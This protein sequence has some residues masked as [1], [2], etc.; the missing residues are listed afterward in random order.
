MIYGAEDIRVE[1]ADD[2]IRKRPEMYIGDMG[3]LGAA[4]LIGL[5][6]E[7]LAALTVNRGTVPCFTH[8]AFLDVVLDG[9]EA[10]VS[11][12]YHPNESPDLSERCIS[13]IGNRNNMQP[14]EYA[15]E[16]GLNSVAPLPILSALSTGLHILRSG[17]NGV[18][19]ILF[20][21]SPLA[22]KPSKSTKGAF[23]AVRFM[24]QDLIDPASLPQ[25]YLEG[26]LQGCSNVPGLVVRNVSV[27]VTA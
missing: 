16:Q 13:L 15:L 21:E 5:A 12:D 25:D 10:T 22:L 26:F 8:H 7:I 9:R 24:F 2:L 23:V 6:V 11:M 1:K 19:T 14:D 17:E 20:D 18:K 27:N 4:R 3:H